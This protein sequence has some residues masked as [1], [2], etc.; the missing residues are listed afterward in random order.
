MFGCDDCGDRRQANHLGTE[1]T[2]EL[3]T[4]STLAALADSV[5]RS[6]AWREPVRPTKPQMSV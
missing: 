2:S 1:E 4:L 6:Q 3:K 5:E